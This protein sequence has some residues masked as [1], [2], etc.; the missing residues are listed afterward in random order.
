MRRVNPPAYGIKRCLLINF[1][2][3]F[4]ILQVPYVHDALGIGSGKH[5]IGVVKLHA[6]DGVIV[7]EHLPLSLV[8]IVIQGVILCVI[9]LNETIDAANC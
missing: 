8:L 2:Q 7:E 4:S 6:T 9:E 3:Q 1:S 5:F